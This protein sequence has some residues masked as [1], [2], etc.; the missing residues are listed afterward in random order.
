ML[1][2]H[3]SF[4]PSLLLHTDDTRRD[5]IEIGFFHFHKLF[6]WQLDVREVLITQRL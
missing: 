1:D 6:K 5:R 3:E 4:T 2:S